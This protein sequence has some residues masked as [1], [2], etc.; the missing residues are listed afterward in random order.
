LFGKAFVNLDEDGKIK[1][2]SDKSKE[3]V[4]LKDIQDARKVQQYYTQK[5]PDI[6]SIIVE[7]EGC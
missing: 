2:F 3:R 4:Y 1:C 7:L 5:N 6:E